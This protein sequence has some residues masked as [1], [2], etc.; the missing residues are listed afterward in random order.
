V[1]GTPLATA[2]VRVRPDTSTFKAETEAGVASAAPAMTKSG[3]K[4]GLTF[5]QAFGKGMGVET[6]SQLKTWQAKLGSELGGATKTLAKIGIAAYVGAAVLAVKAGL[7]LEDTQAA[8]AKAVQN[9]GGGW[10]KINEVLPGA[11]REMQIYG[12][13]QA[14]TNQ[15]LTTMLTAT[16]D[17]STSVLSLG[18]AANLAAVKHI[19]LTD[20]ATMLAKAAGGAS[21]GLKDLGITQVTGATW[22]VA[23]GNAS[24]T[25]SDQIQSAG[26]MAQFAALHH[27][28]LAKATDLVKQATG[29]ASGALDTLAGK[30]FTLAAAQTTVTAALNGNA[31]AQDKLSKAGLTVAQTQDLIKQASG[32]SVKA[33]NELGIS[34]LP[35]SATAAERLA[36]VTDIMD[37]K[38]GGQASAA[39]K[40]T[41]GKIKEMKAE[42]T[43]MA[44]KIGEKI[45]P[46]AERFVKWLSDSGLLIPGLITVMG[47]LTAAIIVQAAAWAMTPMGM[48]TLAIVAIIAAIVLLQQNWDTVWHAIRVA[49]AV[50][51]DAILGFF[52]DI[53]NG[54]ASAF[55]W[56]PGI[57]PKLREA[58]SAFQSWRDSVNESIRGVIPYKTVTINAAFVASGPLSELYRSQV[59]R[60]AGGWIEEPVYGFGL[61]TGRSYSFAEQGRE[62]VSPEGKTPGPT[63]NVGPV[64]VSETADADLLARRLGFLATAG[65]LG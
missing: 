64:L 35:K 50:V 8:L 45:L 44:A 1:A 5:G 65:G 57:G 23:F 30:G 3:G 17:A 15:A 49:T 25:L 2:F 36:Q 42:L 16:G 24:K 4:A 62:Y 21:R 28:T 34:V 31:G 59:P 27:M 13:T 54:I 48:I 9:S 33:L 47:I 40:T 63:I 56:I 26:G 6:S 32:G 22:A 14:Q 39:A 18:A 7:Q 12:F 60:A 58:A 61:R 51:V 37:A 43:D 29:A 53:I 41:A 10:A 38:I 52:G 19:S 11:S 55:G 46:Y 20:A